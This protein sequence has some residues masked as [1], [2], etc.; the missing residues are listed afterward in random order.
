MMELLVPPKKITRLRTGASHILHAE[1]ACSID[2][3]KFDDR[4]A[5]LETATITA[6]QMTHHHLKP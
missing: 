6:R 5:F 2:S 1:D 3:A 4:P